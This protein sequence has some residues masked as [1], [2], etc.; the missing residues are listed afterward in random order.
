MQFTEMIQ[1]INDLE[2]EYENTDYDYRGDD[3]DLQRYRSTDIRLKA[4]GLRLLAEL[5][6]S[7]DHVGNKVEGV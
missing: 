7:I 4:L 3:R 1:Q 2:S 6:S 5:I